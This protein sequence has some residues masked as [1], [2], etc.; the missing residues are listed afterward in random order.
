[1]QTYSYLRKKTN[2]LFTQHYVGRTHDTNSTLWLC[3]LEF[4]WHQVLSLFFSF[5]CTYSCLLTVTFAVH[6]APH[7]HCARAVTIVTRIAWRCVSWKLCWSHFTFGHKQTEWLPH[8]DGV[9]LGQTL[10]EVCSLSC[11]LIGRAGLDDLLC[12]IR[13]WLSLNCRCCA[14]H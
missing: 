10:V 12:T 4:H 2:K 11:S 3:L 5:L 14:Q 13:L 1:M 7:L 9:R 8:S 6:W